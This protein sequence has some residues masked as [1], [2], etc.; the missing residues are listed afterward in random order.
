MSVVVVVLIVAGAF[1][2]TVAAIGMFRFP[3]VF[4]RSHALG[5]T[6][7]FGAMLVLLGLAIHQGPTLN[8]IKILV[9]LVLLF[10]LNPMISHAVVRAALRAG[11]TP[12]T[13]EE[14]KSS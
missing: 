8:A 12:W 7:T 14:K 11:L 5:L 1:F 10:L 9:V 13:K 2:L 3:D 4:T 6:D